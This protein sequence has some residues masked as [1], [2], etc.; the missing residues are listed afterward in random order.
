MN[1]R[2]SEDNRGGKT[3]RSAASAK[4]S[5][6]RAATVREPA[7]KTKK[8]KKAEARERE[9]KLEQKNQALA[10]VDKNRLEDQPEYKRLQTIWKVVIGAAIA[11]LIASFPLSNSESLQFLFIPCMVVAYALVIVSFII[12]F[13]KMG[14]MRKQYERSIPSGKSKEARAAQK[15]ARA[16]ARE[17]LKAAEE[18][19]KLEQ[20]AKEAAG[21]DGA[22]EEEGGLFARFRKRK[23]EEPSQEEN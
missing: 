6:T 3:R 15:K 1:E 12:Y 16:E 5:A 7:P 21:A 23:P 4:P 13:G 14:K 17:Q 20:E 9:R 2:Y 19:A 18:K 22:A 11:L 8:Q 10:S